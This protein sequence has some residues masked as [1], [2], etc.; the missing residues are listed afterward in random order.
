MRLVS[1]PVTGDDIATIREAVSKEADAG[2]DVIIACHS[3]SGSQ[4]NS[5]LSGFSKIER[6]KQGKKGGVVKLVFLC[7][8][9]V[10]EGVSLFDAVGRKEP[11]LWNI[12]VRMLLP[13]YPN[14]D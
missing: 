12:Q 8:F 7:A 3:G 11:E 1:R 14:F 10:P 2:N 5:A 6:E 4:V 13:Y 9:V